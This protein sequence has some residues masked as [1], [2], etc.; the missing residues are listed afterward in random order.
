MRRVLQLPVSSNIQIAKSYRTYLAKLMSGQSKYSNFVFFAE[1]LSGLQVEENDTIKTF[2]IGIQNGHWLMQYSPSMVEHLDEYGAGI[3]ITHEVGH[4]ILSHH[5]RIIK[6][7]DSFGNTTEDALFLRKAKAVI[8]IAADYALNSWL[9]DEL[10]VFS[11]TDLK[12]RVGIP[13]DKE[14]TPRSGVMISSYAGIH[15]SDVGLPL[16]KSMEFYVTELSKRIKEND[17]SRLIRSTADQDGSGTESQSSSGGQG[18]TQ[19]QDSE[20]SQQSSSGKAQSSVK[21]DITGMSKEML[22]VLEGSVDTSNGIFNDQSREEIKESY[23]DIVD[24]DGESMTLQD[25][26]DKLERVIKEAVSKASESCK[27]RGHGAGTFIQK[28]QQIYDKPQVSWQEILR[29]FTQSK[30]CP[31][32]VPTIRKIKRRHIDLAGLGDVSEFPGKRKE[33]HYNIVFAID[34]SASVSDKEVVEILAELNSLQ[35]TKVGTSILVLECDTQI[36]NAYVLDKST[37]ITSVTG[38]GGTDF[39]PVFE[40]VSGKNKELAANISS[41]F[42]VSVPK[43]V[44]LLIY[45]TDGESSLPDNT[46]RIPESKMLWLLTSRGCLPGNWHSRPTAVFGNAD[47]G[48]YIKI[49]K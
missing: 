49:I 40:F 3:V 4:A 21:Q 15:P 35:S 1:V 45:C 33:A 24:I 18:G 23:P 30:R 28:I 11:L 19:E 2:C 41:R 16:G 25:L 13:T 6:M 27:S 9:I 12:T 26:E 47:Y 34:T 39:N 29:L 8:H 5:I 43:N 14:L 10:K 42:A 46:I 20:E 44:D 22:E 17:P 36:S 48:K 7:L 37:K 31:K 38:R 32:K